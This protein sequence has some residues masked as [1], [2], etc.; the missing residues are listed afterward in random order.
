M[1]TMPLQP[2]ENIIDSQLLFYFRERD[3]GLCNPICKQVFIFLIYNEVFLLRVSETGLNFWAQERNKK[4]DNYLFEFS[5][6][7]RVL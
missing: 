5:D 7:L 6:A 3:D 4:H 1:N 2:F